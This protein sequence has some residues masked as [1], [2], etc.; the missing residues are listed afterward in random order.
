MTLVATR[1]DPSSL[2]QLAVALAVAGLPIADLAEPGR[3]FFRFDD[4]ALAGFGGIEGD[5]PDRL[6]RSVV[7]VHARRGAGVGRAIVAQLERLA[8]QAGTDRLHLLTTTAAEFFALAGYDV[9]ERAA[10]PAMIAASRE[11]ASL[12]P[13]NATYLVKTLEA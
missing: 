4:D 11:F 1:L 8:A 5:G 10:A 2:E 13:S 3:T 12:C 9:A 6:L 7:V